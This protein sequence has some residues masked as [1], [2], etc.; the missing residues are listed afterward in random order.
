MSVY[1]EVKVINNIDI[2]LIRQIILALHEIHVDI[3]SSNNIVTTVS[4]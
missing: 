1:S 2:L 4:E 3:E